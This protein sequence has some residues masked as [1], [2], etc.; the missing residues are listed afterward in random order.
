MSMFICSRPIDLVS[1]RYPALRVC[2]FLQ[3]GGCSSTSPTSDTTPQA[4]P[5]IQG[6]PPAK[7]DYDECRIQ[8]IIFY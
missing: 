1:C 7:K 6:P 3:F 5:E 2:L 8:V 4:S